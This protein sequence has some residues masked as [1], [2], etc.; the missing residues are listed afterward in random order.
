MEGS[1]RNRTYRV[2]LGGHLAEEVMV[3]NG[4]PQCS[5]LGAHLFQV[6]RSDLAGEL[7]CYHLFFA[8]YIK[9]IAS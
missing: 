9:L 4:V 8:D 6:F 3:K 1:L 5:V 2:K 7:I